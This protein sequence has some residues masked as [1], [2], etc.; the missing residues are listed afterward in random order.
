MNKT[1]KVFVGTMFSGEGDFEECIQSIN[2]QRNVE[3]KH[4]IVKNLPEREAHNTLFSEWNNQKENFDFFTKIDADTVLSHPFILENFGK[5]FQ[6]NSR[7]TS[8]QAPLHDYFTNELINGL[9]SFVPRVVFNPSPE[10]YCDRVDTNHDVQVKSS[11]VVRE[12]NPAGYHCYSATPRQAFHFGL[13]RK[14]K[15][16]NDIIN[17]VA[18]AYEVNKWPGM[19][20]ARAFALAGAGAASQCAGEHNYTDTKFEELFQKALQEINTKL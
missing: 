16:Q 9:N 10:L 6:S 13:H 8:I 7:F 2:R 1:Y 14:L 11:E 5:M 12:L 3:V 20:D 18:M 15:G 4:F 17:R 19:V